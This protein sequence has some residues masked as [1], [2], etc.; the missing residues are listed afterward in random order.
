MLTVITGPMYSAK[1]NEFINLVETIKKQGLN[2]LVLKPS[3]D[4]RN[5][6]QDI[7]SHDNL[8][9]KSIVF[10]E[11]FEIE[12]FLNKDKYDAIA[13]DE[14][15]FIQD[16]DFVPLINEVANK[17]VEIILSGLDTDFKGEVYG[18]MGDLL[19]LADKVVKKSSD[20]KICGTKAT[21]TQ[22]LVNGKPAR[23]SDPVFAV[24]EYITYEARCRN[25]HEVRN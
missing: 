8:R 4:T 17:G 24:A 1:T 7:V 2:V 12:E 22:R 5:S 10:E 16:W 13:I 18:M 9:T 15:Q 25:H 11:I 3:L 6:H 19:A 21:R 23:K 14:V 20:C